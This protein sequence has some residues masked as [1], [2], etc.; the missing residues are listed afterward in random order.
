MIQP[1][2]L[3]AV[4]IFACL[5]DLQRE[6]IAKNAADLFVQPGEWLIREGEMP[7]FFVLLEGELEV[8]KEYG[9]AGKFGGVISLATSMVKPRFC[10]IHPPS[11]RYARIF[12][13]VF[14]DWTECCFKN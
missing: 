13:P 6:R 7:S 10:S 2:E 12:R 5:T 14:F 9:G 4:P 8:E 3:K 11:H 1:E